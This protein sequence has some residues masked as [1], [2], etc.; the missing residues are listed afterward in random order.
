[1]SVG[2]WQHH[3]TYSASSEIKVLCILCRINSCRCL[4]AKMLLFAE[5]SDIFLILLPFVPR[6][7]ELQHAQGTLSPSAHIK[8]WAYLH[9]GW[10]KM[11][12]WHLIAGLLF[13]RSPAAGLLIPSSRRVDNMQREN[14]VGKA[15]KMNGKD[16]V[17]VMMQSKGKAGFIRLQN[18]IRSGRIWKGTNN[19][20]TADGNAR[21]QS[22]P[23]AGWITMSVGREDG[24]LYRKLRRS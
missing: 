11:N 10:K 24:L 4:L 7:L 23:K 21:Q 3:I 22:S 18:S 6:C 20:N 16:T 13:F 12:R 15:G 2:E 8:H 14:A 9:R 19:A 1:M 17:P 5:K